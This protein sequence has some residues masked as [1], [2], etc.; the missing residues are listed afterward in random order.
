MKNSLY[1]LKSIKNIQIDK[2]KIQVFYKFLK[3][4]WQIFLFFKR[5]D[6]SK[7]DADYVIK[8]GFFCY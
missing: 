7:F 6:C 3:I 4:S 8:N 1:F 2:N 5:L